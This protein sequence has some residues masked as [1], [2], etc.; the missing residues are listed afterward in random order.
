MER[1]RSIWATNSRPRLLLAQLL[2]SACVRVR[3]CCLRPRHSLSLSPSER[4]RPKIFWFKVTSLKRGCESSSGSVRPSKREHRGKSDGEIGLQSNQS[5]LKILSRRDSEVLSSQNQWFTHKRGP[6]NNTSSND[7]KMTKGYKRPYKT[8]CQWLI[9]CVFIL[10]RF[11]ISIVIVGCAPGR[12]AKTF[13]C[14]V[15]IKLSLVTHKSS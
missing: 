2:Q 15:K 7:H 10:L 5:Q 13:I 12:T 14:S 8:H 1:P 11:P 9:Y 6:I 3:C 4:A